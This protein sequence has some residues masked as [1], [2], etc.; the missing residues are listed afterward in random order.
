MYRLLSKNDITFNNQKLKKGL[1][2]PKNFKF[3]PILKSKYKTK[4]SS[5]EPVENEIAPKFDFSAYKKDIFECELKQKLVKVFSEMQEKFPQAFV[6][7]G[8]PLNCFRYSL[9]YDKNLPAN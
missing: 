3:K 5:K 4:P 7:D 8:N 1:L 9:S 6:S 2:L